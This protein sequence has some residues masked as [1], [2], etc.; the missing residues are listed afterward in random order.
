MPEKDETRPVSTP[1]EPNPPATDL[2]EQGTSSSGD[3]EKTLSKQEMAYRKLQA[4]RDRREAE[5]RKR[6]ADKDAII[7]DYEARFAEESSQ[8]EYVRERE[9]DILEFERVR[10]QIET[11][12]REMP[13]LDETFFASATN[14]AEFNAGYALAVKAFNAKYSE[15]KAE[16]A[17]AERAAENRERQENLPPTPK[18]SPT[19]V[20]PT[21]F[22][23]WREKAKKEKG[24][25]EDKGLEFLV[26]ARN[27]GGSGGPGSPKTPRT[28]KV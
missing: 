21:D 27:I 14:M 3:S 8:R 15:E 10:N 7:A 19:P 17:R 2:P 6:L 22:E 28:S 1:V 25:K 12:K 26:R 24:S 16:K 23:A 18:T 4:E 5:L 11:L 20:P 9:T 13:F